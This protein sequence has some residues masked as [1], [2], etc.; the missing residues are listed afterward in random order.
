MKKDGRQSRNIEIRPYE[1]PSGISDYY[2]PEKVTRQPPDTAATRASAGSA[3]DMAPR[4]DMA[5]QAGINSMDAAAQHDAQI[6]LGSYTRKE[7]TPPLKK[8]GR[9]RWNEN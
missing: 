1:K 8:T 9:T 2:S 4:N 6:G 7:K 3:R 5:V